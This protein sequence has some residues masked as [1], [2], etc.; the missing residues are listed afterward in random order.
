M[1]AR[2]HMDRGRHEPMLSCTTHRC[3]IP[4][5]VMAGCSG[6]GFPG[7]GLSAPG[8]FASLLSSH[9]RSTSRDMEKRELMNAI[10]V[11]ISGAFLSCPLASPLG[12]PDR[13]TRRGLRVFA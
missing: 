4:V 6:E 7:H 10:H 12:F 2:G 5:P 8:L 11:C 3:S 9:G 1:H 13:A